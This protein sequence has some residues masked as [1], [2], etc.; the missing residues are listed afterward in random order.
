MWA[1][2]NG[3]GHL[4]VDYPKLLKYG[5]RG[6]INQI[7]KKLSALDIDNPEDLEKLYFYQSLV[8][9][10]EAAVRFAN[11]FADLAE[12]KAENAEDPKRKNELLEIADICRNVPENP[13]ESFREAV[14]ALWFAQLI[15]QLETNG[16]SVSIG[17]F[18]QF[19]YPF[20]K[21]DIEGKRLTEEKAL[22]IL[23][24]FWIKLNSVTKLRS[25][26]QTR[27]NAGFPMFQNLTIGGQKTNGEDAANQLTYLLLDCHDSMRL[28]QPTL[29]ARVHKN[30]PYVFLRRCVEVLSKGGGMPAFFNDEIIIPSLLLRGVQK[31]DA[32]NYCMV[33][34]VE[35]SVAGKWGGRYGAS[36]FN[37]T[38]C[39]ELA[40]NGGKD[41]RTGIMLHGNDKTLKDFVDYREVFDAFKDQLSHYIRL[42]TIMDNIQDMVWETM[43]PTPFVSGLVSDCIERGREIKR[44]GAVYDFS[45]GQAG[46][47]ANVANSLAAI[48]KL[49]FEEKVISKEKLQEALETNF[50]GQ[51][52]EQIRQT[53]INRAPKYGNDDDYVDSIAKEAFTHYLKETGKHRNTRYGRGPIGGTFHPSTASVAYNVPAGTI[54]GATP[55][56]RK[57]GEPL[58]DVESPFRGTELNGPTAVVKSASKLEHIL[59]SGGS[60]LN[61]KFN[62]SI[63][64]DPRQL[65]NLVA[66]ITGF[67]EL[68]GME[69]QILIVPAE[70]LRAAQKTPEKYRDLLVRVAGYSTFFVALDPEIQNDIIA[71]TEHQGF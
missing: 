31:E 30:S 55:D 6:I 70:N 43:L 35:P 52:G 3:D 20:F 27:L 15:I 67:F 4:A 38:K 61:L 62:P 25:W 36:L 7:S 32:Y 59:E 16:H 19:M 53:L 34:C 1:L 47:I 54:T 65:D 46:N 21:R 68:K 58:A 60:I 29:T 23:Q 66:L 24:C 44:G 71:R 40:L 64:N 39:L 12:Q 37:L 49:I 10:Y 56:G 42:Y 17:R 48:R 11:R 8:I 51:Q 26:S 33:G 22:E 45:G 63:F 50:E 57:A 5:F 9:V 69:V 18:D 13:A 41:P 14:Q 28:S 2:E